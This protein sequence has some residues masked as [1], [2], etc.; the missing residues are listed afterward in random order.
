MYLMHVN[1]AVA[2]DLSLNAFDFAATLTP[3][4]LLQ[5]ACCRCALR[6]A[7]PQRQPPPQQAE[8]DGAIWPQ[9]QHQPSS[10]WQLDVPRPQQGLLEDPAWCVSTSV[11]RC[12][13][14]APPLRSLSHLPPCIALCSICRHAAPQD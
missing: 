9:E 2:C 3:L 10:R 7:E 5:P 1:N 6:G 8:V 13:C 11:A 12:L 14:C 4:T